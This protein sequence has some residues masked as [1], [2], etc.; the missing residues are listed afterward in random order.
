MIISL[1]AAVLLIQT[2]LFIIN[3]IGA[4]AINEVVRNTLPTPQP[5]NKNQITNN[6]QLWQLSAR[7]PLASSKDAQDQ[8]KLRREVLRLKKEM[9]A[10]SAQ[11]NFARWAKIRREHDRAMAAHDQK[12]E[13]HY[14]YSPALQRRDRD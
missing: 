11:D 8:L 4:K 12:G 9:N 1:F 14:N 5:K 13:S 7:L 10:V 2:L 3:A 6:S